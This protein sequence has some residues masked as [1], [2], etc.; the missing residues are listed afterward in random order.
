VQRIVGNECDRTRNKMI[1]ACLEFPEET[2]E[3]HENFQLK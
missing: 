2:K 1:D 3:D